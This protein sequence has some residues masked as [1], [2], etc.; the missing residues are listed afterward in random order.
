MW[1]DGV[2]VCTWWLLRD[3]PMETTPFQS[4]LY[5][6]GATIA[7]DTPKPTLTAFR[8]PFVAFPRAKG[9]FVWGRVPRSD[10]RSVVIEQQMGPRW[11]RLA[12]LRSDRNGIFQAVLPLRANDGYLR[13]RLGDGSSRSL[14]FGLKAVPDERVS[15]WGGA[16]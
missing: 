2:A 4:G 8:F 3:M 13:A 15:P 14:P 9:T 5:L 16:A 7:Q 12:R 1:S 10:A 6:A 11:R